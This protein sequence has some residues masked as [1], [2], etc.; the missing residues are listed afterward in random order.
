METIHVNKNVVILDARGKDVSDDVIA[1]KINRALGFE[2]I[3]TQLDNR[4][5]GEGLYIGPRAQANI[6]RMASI[7][8]KIYVGSRQSMQPKQTRALVLKHVKGL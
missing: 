5:P 3:G 7:D 4:Q 2:T 8:P 1:E 6:Y